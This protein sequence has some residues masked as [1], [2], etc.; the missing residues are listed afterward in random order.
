MA[1]VGRPVSSRTGDVS[2]ASNVKVRVGVRQ[3][4][5][6]STDI[7]KIRKIRGMI[8]GVSV[9]PTGVGPG[10]STR[11]RPDA[12][13]FLNR[14]RRPGRAISGPLSQVNRGISRPSEPVARRGQRGQ[15]ADLG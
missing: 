13:S 12:S 14:V 3:R 5:R 7:R 11:S 2:T 10:R 15:R 9:A 6:S 1:L 4:T 8:K